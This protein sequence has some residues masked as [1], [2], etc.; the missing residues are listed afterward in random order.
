MQ[1]ISAG[2]PTTQRFQE[3]AEVSRQMK[4]LAMDLGITIVLVC[5]LDAPPSGRAL[6]Q[7][8]LRGPSAA[9]EHDA[10]VLIFLHRDDYYD[11]ESPRAGEADIIVA[12]HR[13]G[14]TDTI[15]VAAQLHLGRFVDMVF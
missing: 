3:I 5:Q 10:D 13:D 12:K 4:L 14:P 7:H 9:L 2:H 6:P 1:A 8:D 15:T 11:K